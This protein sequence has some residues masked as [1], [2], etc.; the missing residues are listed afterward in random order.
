MALLRHL[1]VT[2]ITLSLASLAAG[3]AGAEHALT[4]SEAVRM[5]LEKNQ[6]LVIERE[7]VTIANA[8]VRGARG[9]YDPVLELNGGWSRSQEP[10]NSVFSGA[11]LGHLGPEF[12]VTE[13]GGGLFQ[14]LPTGGTLALTA[15]GLKQTTDGAAV[16]LSPAYGTR[17]GIELR[18]PLLRD[19]AVDDVR[20]RLRVAHADRG[21]A[22][23]SLRRSA[24]STVA[25]V[26][27]AYWRLVAVRQALAVREDAVHLAEQQLEETRS[28]VQTGA[29]PGTELSQPRAE[30]ERRRGELLAD[31]ETQARAQSALK[32]LILPDADAAR[33]LE[34]L[35]P[36]DTASVVAETVD[37]AG[38]LDQAL[39][40]RP[41]LDEARAALE[42]RHAETA[43]AR[44]GVW[45]SLDAVA[46]YER[47]GLSGTKNPSAP[48]GG[49]PSGLSGD[50]SG[51]LSALSDGE[52]D[53]AR[54][55]VV[56]G[57][58]I[59]NRTARS[60]VAAAQGAERQAEAQ[61]VGVR[62]SICA[63]VLDAA[64]AIETAAQRVAAARAGREAAEIQFEAERD[65]FTS[66][67]STN[68]L[69]LTRQNDLSRARLDEIAARTDYEIAR[70]QL[71]HATGSL[72][73]AHGIDV[74]SPTR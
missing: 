48:A 31:R 14:Y 5:A 58:P 33:W 39:S 3:R 53:A 49:L 68:F 20:L 44:S 25:D 52:T 13:A 18:Q 65:R 66:G 9:A 56:L 62:K 19:L 4:L 34:P 36:T 2:V 17:V 46:S 6:E 47:F 69:V 67:R 55:G 74:P 11:P 35:A 15:H 71:A 8:N 38:V 12:E 27:R 72:I 40:S 45:P 21:A 57:L 1:R 32:F 7:G 22:V 60:A 59:T 29:V 73:Q 16:L 28:R 54:V 61:L 51:A 50:L 26:E 43:R 10:V 41:E 37:R 42:R 30:L 24:A 63:E 64:A 23:A 70:T